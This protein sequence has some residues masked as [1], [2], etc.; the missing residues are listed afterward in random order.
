VEEKDQSEAVSPDLPSCESVDTLAKTRSRRNNRATISYKD[1]SSSSEEEESEDADD[2]LFAGLS[3]TE[4]DE[5]RSK[6]NQ[7]QTEHTENIEKERKLKMEEIIASFDLNL[8]EKVNLEEAGFIYDF[9][10]KHQFDVNDKIEDEGDF[11]LMSM[12]E[13]IEE[14]KKLISIGI[15]AGNKNKNIRKKTKYDE[16]ESEFD[17]NDYED[18][19]SD[20]DFSCSDWEDPE[21]DHE[22]MISEDEDYEYGK[23]RRKKRKRNKNVWTDKDGKQYQCNGRLLL[24]DA[25][26]DTENFEGWS[27]ARVQAWKNKEVNPNA[28]YYRFNDP[29]E[30]QKNGRIGMDEHKMFMERVKELGVNMHWGTFSMK[31][32]GRVGYQCSNYWRQM[33]KDEWVKDPNYWIRADQSFQFKR[34]KKGSIPDSVRKFSFVV[35]KDPSKTF[36]PLPGV[37]PKRPSDKIMNKFLSENVKDLKNKK[38]GKKTKK[39]E[40][41]NNK[42][43]EMEDDEDEEVENK[44]KRKKAVIKKNKNNKNDPKPKDVNKPKQSASSYLLFCNEVRND[45]KEKH[46]EKK[47]G[48]LSKLIALEWNGMNDEDKKKYVEKGKELRSEYNKKLEE[49]KASEKYQEYLQ[50]LKEWNERQMDVQENNEEKEK[51]EEKEKGKEKIEEKAKEKTEE[52]EKGK[53]KEKGRKRKLSEDGQSEIEP[54]A[55][56]RKMKGKK[57]KNKNKNEKEEKEKDLILGEMTDIM[58]GDTMKRPAISPYGHVME[59]DSWCS[60]LRNAKTKNQ[61]PFTKQKLTRRSLVKLDE[62]NIEEYKDKI[63]NITRKEKKMLN[64]I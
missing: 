22:N 42:K 10:R 15:R 48:E 41:K 26:K 33:M 36:H 4:R 17:L 43:Q 16:S 12:R 19:D 61:C 60:I 6:M 62:N 35:L 11:F 1:E 38:K 58:T 30:A 20:S 59:Y 50:K 37:H 32:P 27:A 23:K 51:I 7:I 55:K 28:Y 14:K 46:P 8:G 5:L 40:N 54:P 39:N 3:K 64:K 47:M 45:F 29:G 18:T 13:M 21:Q 25:L 34:A 56:K 57:G 49:Y 53:K 31:I 24:D 2:A 63:V 44:N 9:C 52:K